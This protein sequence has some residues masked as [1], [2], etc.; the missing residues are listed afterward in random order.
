M[1]FLI[2]AID[3]ATLAI[4]DYYP[5]SQSGMV[6]YDHASYERKDRMSG[7]QYKPYKPEE[8]VSE[9]EKKKEQQEIREAGKRAAQEMAGEELG[10]EKP[11]S[12][13]EAEKE[14]REAARRARQEKQK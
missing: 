4:Q 2:R 7:E 3:V 8:P 10:E 11:M 13:E 12:K 5:L 14:M 9:E 6:L 1:H